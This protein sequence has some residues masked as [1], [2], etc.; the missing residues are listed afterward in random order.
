MHEQPDL[1]EPAVGDVGG[2]FVGLVDCGTDLLGCVP[3]DADHFLKFIQRGGGGG[4]DL[5]KRRLQ[6]KGL[7]TPEPEI[8]VDDIT[9]AVDKVEV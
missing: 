9:A 2:E 1:I 6:I 5:G 7:F 8:S 4:A 3:S